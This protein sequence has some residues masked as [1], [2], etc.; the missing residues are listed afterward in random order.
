MPDFIKE[1]QHG[2]YRYRTK[3]QHRQIPIPCVRSRRIYYQKWQN[4]IQALQYKTKQALLGLLS[5]VSVLDVNGV[6]CEK[7]FD[8]P[9]A[10]YEDALLA[11]CGKRHKVGF[12]VTRNANHY[13]GSPVKAVNL[14]EILGSIII[15]LTNAD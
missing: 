6:D 5:I 4:C 11:Q 10:D 9:M 2:Y 13:E 14:D 7:A 3:E 1:L 12:I 15:R 8:L